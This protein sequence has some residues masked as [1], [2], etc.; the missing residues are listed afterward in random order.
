MFTRLSIRYSPARVLPNSRSWVTCRV[1]FVCLVLAGSAG[2][3]APQRTWKLG[4]DPDTM[5]ATTFLH[6]L[7]ATPVVSV[8]EGMRAVLMLTDEGS[9]FPT[10]ERR[11]EELLRRS[12]IKPQWKLQADQVLDKGTLAHMLRVA[13]QLPR[14]VNERLFSPLN[15]GDR[16]YALHS[17]V[18][19]GLLGYSLP[20]EPVRG[21]ELLSAMTAAEQYLSR[22]T[23]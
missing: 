12:A 9:R 17:C 11:R 20:S 10:Y 15:L 23:P 6:Y 3:Q 19:A 2:C 18:H 1:W 13:C 7:A 14:S 5:N 8:D 16:R 4:R 22:R 21:G